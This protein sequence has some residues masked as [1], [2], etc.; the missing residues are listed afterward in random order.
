MEGWIMADIR[1]SAL[2]GIPFGG[3]T[4]RPT[5]PQTGQPFFN[6][7][8]ARLELYTA[9]T[10]WQNIVQETPGVSSINGNYSEQTDSGVITIY[11]TNFVSGCYATAIGSNGVQ[12]DAGSTVFNSI[13]QVTATFTGLS[14]AYEP[15][16]IKVT[17][18][19][20]LFGIIP[21][22]LYVNQTPL[23][24]TPSGNIATFTE[25]IQNSVTI[26]ASDS[27]NLPLTYTIV[28]GALPSGITLNSSTGVISG[29]GPSTSSNTTYTF[30]VTA[31]DGINTSA[32]R[33][34]NIIMSPAYAEI[35]V[36]A[37][38]GGGGYHGGTG[39]NGGGGA[40]GLAYAAQ[41]DIFPGSYLVSVGAGGSGGSLS[42]SVKRGNSGTDSRF[43]SIIANG[44]GYGGAGNELGSYN[45]GA[46]G[47]GGGATAD[48]TALAGSATQTSGTGYIGYG[49][50]GGTGSNLG[51]GHAGA[52]G[53][54]AG[55][56]GGNGVSNGSTD[57][58]GTGGLGKAYSIT[59]TTAHYAA[60]GGGGSYLS[61]VSYVTP[62]AS[63]IGGRGYYASGETKI[64]APELDGIA[65]TGSGGGGIRYSSIDRAG[66]GA[67]GVVIIA[68]PNTYPALTIPGTLTYDTPTRTGYRVYRFT[69]G[70]GTVSV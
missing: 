69:A 31:S 1:T 49:F 53:G 52:G 44:G 33:S 32:P 25:L 38:G 34:F 18:P 11:G 68:Y 3:N 60:G 2:G 8:A 61:N 70:S 9:S 48:S 19:S 39:S 62:R 21:D 16:D 42:S 36:V 47:S 20:N 51:G 26:S 29:I 54:G 17:N 4:G 45:G 23:W 56:A 13:V 6:G 55:A 24:Q 10:G 64:S 50:A 28:S 66:N 63:G 59:G 67:D 40:G 58:G 14:A 27:E 7:E 35:L 43:G 37:G 12:V 5:N 57:T 65:N 41:Y 46:G 15:Y 22:A 30:S